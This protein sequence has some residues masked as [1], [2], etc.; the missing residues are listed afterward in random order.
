[1][2]YRGSRHDRNLRFHSAQSGLLCL[3]YKINGTSILPLELETLTFKEAVSRCYQP[4]L[5]ESD[6]PNCALTITAHSGA[7]HVEVISSRVITGTE[8]LYRGTAIIRFHV[9]EAHESY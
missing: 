3:I 1:M 5:L 6:A 4:S 2:T 9:R 8:K 7:P